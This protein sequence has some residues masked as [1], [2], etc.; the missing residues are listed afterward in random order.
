[1]HGLRL[2][3]KVRDLEIGA[4]DLRSAPRRPAVNV[5]RTSKAVMATLSTGSKTECTTVPDVNSATNLAASF[6][7]SGG[8][9]IGAR[10]VTITTGAESIS[11]VGGFSVIAV[12]PATISWSCPTRLQHPECPSSS[13]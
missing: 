13:P 4:A 2:G 9:T 6:T 11:L 7:I 12:G 3:G 5:E 1:M 8:A 10:D